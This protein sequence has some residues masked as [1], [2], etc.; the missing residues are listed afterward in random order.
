MAIHGGCWAFAPCRPCCYCL[1]LCFPSSIL[2]AL[3]CGSVVQW[4]PGHAAVPCRCVCKKS[5]RSQHKYC[6][7]LDLLLPVLNFQGDDPSRVLSVSRPAR[8]HSP[9]QQLQDKQGCSCSSSSLCSLDCSRGGSSS[10]SSGR[11]SSK[12]EE[13]AEEVSIACDLQ[14]SVD[15][16]GLVACMQSV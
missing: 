11:S 9:C 2:V 7:L 14:Q 4:Y 5:V 15:G 10:S 12:E 6:L 16:Q 8:Q 3:L 1:M 13:E